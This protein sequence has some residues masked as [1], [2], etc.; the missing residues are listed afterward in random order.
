LLR[1]PAGIHSRPHAL[2]KVRPEGLREGD[3][4]MREERRRKEAMGGKEVVEV[5]EA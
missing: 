4:V 5:E 1:L 2:D 3:R